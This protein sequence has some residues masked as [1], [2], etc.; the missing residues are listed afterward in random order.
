M[1][2]GGLILKP[3]GQTGDTREDLPVS[4]ENPRRHASNRVATDKRILTVR[5][6][7]QNKRAIPF[8]SKF[9]QKR[10]AAVACVNT[11]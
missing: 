7:A 8:T 10:G 5:Q 11:R 9:H 1:A 6:L 3:Y 4:A 2:V